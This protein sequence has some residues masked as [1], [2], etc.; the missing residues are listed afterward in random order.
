MFIF[1]CAN[2]AAGDNAAERDAILQAW[3]QDTRLKA[4]SLG[5]ARFGIVP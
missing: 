2:T 1:V 5:L 4:V 3:A